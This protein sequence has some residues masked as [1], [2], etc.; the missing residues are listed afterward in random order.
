MQQPQQYCIN[1]IQNCD[2]VDLDKTNCLEIR[3]S[4]KIGSFQKLLN[5][6]RKIMTLICS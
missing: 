3:L 6:A 5:P 4:M 1:E 2:N